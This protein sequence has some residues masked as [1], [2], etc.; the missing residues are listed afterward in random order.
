MEIRLNQADL[1]AVGV[2]L[3]GVRSAYPRVI[4]RSINATL[5][6]TRTRAVSQISAVLNLTATRIRQDLH[7][8][9]RFYI[10]HEGRREPRR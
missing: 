3:D 1:N 4:Y 8:W 10:H 2:M 5:G 6:N 9:T 7:G